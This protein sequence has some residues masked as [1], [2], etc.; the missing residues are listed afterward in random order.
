VGPFSFLTRI[1]ASATF[2]LRV[3]GST[4]PNRA[5]MRICDLNTQTMSVPPMQPFL[6]TPAGVTDS[7]ST[8]SLIY[9]QIL[10]AST[11]ARIALGGYS[12]DVVAPYGSASVLNA[13]LTVE[14]IKK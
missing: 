12:A 7:D 6:E 5:M 9:E 14:V 8:G 10:P 1:R 2:S 3:S 4:T 11:V 13:V